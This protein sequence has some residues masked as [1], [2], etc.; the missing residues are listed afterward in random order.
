MRLNRGAGHVH[1]PLDKAFA[2]A[3]DCRA[4]PDETLSQIKRRYGATL[5][6]P[7]QPSPNARTTLASPLTISD[8]RYWRLAELNRE[9][10]DVG[11][12]V[13]KQ[14]WSSRD[15]TAANDPKPP[16]SQSL[17]TSLFWVSSQTSEV[18]LGV[19]KPH[20]ISSLV[21][22]RVVSPGTSNFLR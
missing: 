20:E 19:W 10:R 13:Q 21:T 18:L 17:M 22:R 16:S 2:I 9:A 4:K 11:L 6:A 15:M 14:T 3:Q 1:F 5:D 12:G 8:V 7:Q